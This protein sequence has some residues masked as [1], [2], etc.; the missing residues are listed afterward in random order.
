MKRQMD[1]DSQMM[2]V[3]LNIG[4]QTKQISSET[5]YVMRG[6]E[7]LSGFNAGPNSTTGEYFELSVNPT[8]LTGTRVQSLAKNFQK[9]RFKRLELK[10]AVNTSTTTTGSGLVGYFENPDQ[11]IS[12]ITALNQIYANPGA[13]Q[14][15]W[16][17][18]AKIKARITDRKWY[19]VDQDSAELMLTTQGKFAIGVV[20]PPSQELIVPL[21][22]DYEVEFMGATIQ[23]YAVPTR[24]GKVIATFYDPIDPTTFLAE[25]NSKLALGPWIASVSIPL[26]GE[27]SA[28]SPFTIEATVYEVI[29][30]DGD[31]V[32]FYRTLGDY[33]NGLPINHEALDLVGKLR[34]EQDAIVYSITGN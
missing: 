20:Q 31:K 15:P 10:V 1:R 9:Y 34:V 21:I 6:S 28:G 33:V 16:W 30:N 4:Y 27:T 7:I 19:N 11:A 24:S 26:F 29:G 32:R 17:Q 22:V 8:T 25:F 2:Q 13:T 23:D 18:Q 12:A 14:F 5:P 3:P